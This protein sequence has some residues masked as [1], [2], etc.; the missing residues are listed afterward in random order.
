MGRH[1]TVDMYAWR[2]KARATAM[3]N[4]TSSLMSNAKWRLLFQALEDAGIEAVCTAKFVCD[5]SVLPLASP[6]LYPP[7]AYI[8]LLNVYPLVDIEWIEFR[9][10]YKRKRTDKL[11]GEMLTQDLDA[12]RIAIE[13]TGKHFPLD[14]SEE[15]IRV[16]GHVK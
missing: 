11:P 7:W 13:S 3:K 12:I 9:Q 5:E 6:N 8:S 10:S 14:V 15:A 2:V 1:D 4:Y 16:V